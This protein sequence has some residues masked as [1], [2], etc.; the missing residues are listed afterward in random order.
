MYQL[1]NF[2]KILKIIPKNNKEVIKMAVVEKKKEEIQ[3]NEG[4]EQEI[5]YQVYPDIFKDID[6]VQKKVELEVVIPGVKKE[7]ISLKVLPTWFKITARRDGIEYLANSSFGV[8][9]VPK[10]T[11]AEYFQ[12]LLKIHAV[13][14]DPLDDARK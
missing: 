7:N 6:Y 13:I 8:E 11:T 12:G 9:I 14:K 5:M 2:K 4:S 10:K 3:E 1:I